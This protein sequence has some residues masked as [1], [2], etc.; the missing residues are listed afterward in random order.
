MRKLKPRHRKWLKETLLL[1]ITTWKRWAYFVCFL[2]VLC[3]GYPARL[4]TY[5][6][7]KAGMSSAPTELRVCWMRLMARQLHPSLRTEGRC[8]GISAGGDLTQTGCDQGSFPRGSDMQSQTRVQGIWVHQGKTRAQM[9]TRARSAR[10]GKLKWS[11][12][13][14][15]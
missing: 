5:S 11:A 1:P 3:T 7:D 12:E 15:P 4:W 9:G 14:L 10:Q 13:S 8:W 6:A 2:S